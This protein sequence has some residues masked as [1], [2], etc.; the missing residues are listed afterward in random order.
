MNRNITGN[1]TRRGICRPHVR[2]R[3]LARMIGDQRAA[4]SGCFSSPAA[5]CAL[6]LGCIAGSARAARL[7]GLLGS[8]RGR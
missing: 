1:V 7:A 2:A 8:H 4:R 3:F 6:A 5:F